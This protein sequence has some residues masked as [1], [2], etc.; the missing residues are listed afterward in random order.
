MHVES[1]RKKTPQTED[2]TSEVK[3]KIVKAVVAAAE[4]RLRLPTLR[5]GTPKELGEGE[6]TDVNGTRWK[7][8]SARTTSEREPFK[9]SGR[10]YNL[11]RPAT[12]VIATLSDSPSTMQ[13]TDSVQ[14]AEWGM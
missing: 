1:S 2:L 14:S 4:R 11:V 6:W 10:Q 9:A 5:L 3:A 7:V 12:A 8:G 13:P